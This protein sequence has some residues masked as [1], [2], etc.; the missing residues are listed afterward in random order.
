MKKKILAVLGSGGH[1]AQ[2]L[3]LLN[4]F[5]DKYVYEYLINDDD[6]VTRKKISGKIYTL[7]NPRVFNENIFLKIIKTIY[8]F[9][10]SINI[11]IKSKPYAILSAGPGLTISLFYAAKLLGKKLIFLESWCRVN[12]KSVSGRFCYPISDLFFIQWK[13]LKKLYPKAIY[14]GRL[15]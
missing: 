2:M 11:L 5:G 12:T 8:G 9:F 7:P 15:S 1:T 10:K 6:L 3:K 4:L 13:D 14:A